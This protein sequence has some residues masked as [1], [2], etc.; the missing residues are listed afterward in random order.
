MNSITFLLVSDIHS[1]PLIECRPGEESQGLLEQLLQVEQAGTILEL[2][3]RV[4]NHSHAE[5]LANAEQVRTLFRK[6]GREVYHI[7]GNHDLKYLSLEENRIA[8]SNYLPYYSRLIAGYHFI[9]LN[10]SDPVMRTCMGH[11]SREQLDWLGEELDAHPGCLKIVCGHHP[12]HPQH[13]DGNPFF[14]RIPG[15]ELIQNGEELQQ[16]LMQH[17]EVIC[18]LNGHVHWF[19]AATVKNLACVSVPSFIEQYPQKQNAAGRYCVLSLEGRHLEITYKTI[20]PRRVLGR[21]EYD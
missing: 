6:S 18:Y 21:I 3:D 1:G 11:V 14:T 12:F 17:D 15:E 16:I 8:V 19:Y 4:N 20:N 5:D 13:M 7:L 9:F 10:T 2:G